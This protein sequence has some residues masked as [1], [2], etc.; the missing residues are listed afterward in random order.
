MA[1]QAGTQNA[2]P[3]PRTAVVIGG[4]R[5]PF[6]RAGGAYA[7]SSNRDMLIAALDGLVARFGLQGE[8][9]GEVAAGAVLK[10]S[11]DFNLTR[12]AVLG[13]ALSPATP[14]YD[15]QQACAT[16]LET[17]VGLSNKIKLGQIESGIAGG[18]DSASDAPIA[19]SEGLRRALLDLSRAKTTQQKIRILSKLRPRDLSPNAPGTGEPRTGLSMGEHQ[20]ITTAAWQITREAQDDLAYRSHQNLAAAFERDFFS[21]LMTPYRGLTRDANLRADTS[22]EKL[23]TLKPV[24]GTGLDTPATMT[25]GNSTPLT[26]GAAVVLLGSEEYARTNN[27]PM[28]ANVVDAEAA[29]V[30]FVHGEEGLLMAPVHAMP[31]LLERNGLTFDDFDF[32]EIHEAFAGTVLSSIAAWEDE[33]YCTRVL[34]LDGA[35]GSIDR[36]RL[37]VHGSSLATGH[38]FAAT[39]GRIVASLGKTLSEQ[40]GRG[41]ISVCAAGGQGVVAILEARN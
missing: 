2:A 32:F 31:R 39:G 5:I 1:D 30:D 16:G 6:A 9:I 10:H 8:R 35:L 34:G 24:F 26:D 28:L 21:D 29:A 37:N 14:A 17:V 19:V 20:A 23:A 22:L 18:V 11:R 15:L 3:S 7:Y 40:G 25:A 12:E 33:D 4:N 36:S 27:L 38:P 41:L 13:S